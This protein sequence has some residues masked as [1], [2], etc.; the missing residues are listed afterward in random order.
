MDSAE[1]LP[2]LKLKKRP[3][4]TRS[5]NQANKSVLM[6]SKAGLRCQSKSP[7]ST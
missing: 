2:L 5:S 1:C 4:S 3:S 7:P 6:I